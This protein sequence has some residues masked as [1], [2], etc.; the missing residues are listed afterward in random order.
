MPDS[1]PAQAA[2]AAAAPDRPERL[3][4][5]ERIVVSHQRRLYHF[6]LRRVGSPDDAADLTQQTFLCAYK[7]LDNFR[8]EAS[9]STWLFGVALTLI[10]NFR[11][12]SEGR[13]RDHDPIDE[14]FDL[15]D[16]GENPEA[17][18][19]GRER[20]R[21]LMEALRALAPE[22]RDVVMLICFEEHSYEDAARLLDIP[23]GTVRSRL[24]RARARLREAL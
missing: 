16:P 9:M 1:V 7:A 20:L 17:S 13:R 10:R 21:H 4:E 5:L 22:M 23:I 3:R 12:R 24:S 6:I 8:G 15:A 19:S 14:M 11:S 18:V 2:P